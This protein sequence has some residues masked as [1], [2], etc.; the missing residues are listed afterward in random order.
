MTRQK[1]ELIKKLYEIEAF[2]AAD[3]QLGCVIYRGC[4]GHMCEGSYLRCNLRQE[5][6][7]KP[8][9]RRVA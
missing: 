8:A 5:Q 1:K 3:S 4:A 9:G 2:I 6:D 7:C